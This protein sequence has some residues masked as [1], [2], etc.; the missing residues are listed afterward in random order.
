MKE[1]TKHALIKGFLMDVVATPSWKRA[2]RVT[3]FA[4]RLEDQSVYERHSTDLFFDQEE[5]RAVGMWAQ[6][7]P[8]ALNQIHQTIEASAQQVRDRIQREFSYAA[9]FGEV[10]GA[11]S[12]LRQL[13][14]GLNKRIEHLAGNLSQTVCVLLRSVESSTLELN[15]MIQIVISPEEDGFQ[16]SF[17]EAKL[18]AYGES[19]EEALQNIGQVIVE[20][21]SRLHELSDDRLGRSML[22]RKQILTRY[23]REV[24]VR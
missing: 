7:E 12:A 9:R 21:Y 6:I 8:T 15:D 22:R 3:S 13:I 17:L 20:A 2:G 10:A 24:P 19:R 14:E 18:H 23:L 16:A 11:L 5:Q 4:G 1:S